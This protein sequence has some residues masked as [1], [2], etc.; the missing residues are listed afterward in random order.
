MGEGSV[1]LFGFQ[2]ED[3]FDVPLRHLSGRMVGLDHPLGGSIRV[4]TIRADHAPLPK[5]NGEHLDAVAP[6]APFNAAA[7]R[8]HSLSFCCGVFTFESAFGFERSR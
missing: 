3:R 4:C 8:Q 1:P 6:F 2:A 5:E 7:E